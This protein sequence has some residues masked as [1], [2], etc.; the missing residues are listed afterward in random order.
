MLSEESSHSRF[1]IV[2][3][4][5][6]VR[7][8]ATCHQCESEQEYVVRSMTYLMSSSPNRESQRDR[9]PRSQAQKLSF[10]GRLWLLY[11]SNLIRC[12]WINRQRNLPN[13][14]EPWTVVRPR[15]ASN[16]LARLCSTKTTVPHLKRVP[17]G[18]RQPV[19]GLSSP[20]GAGS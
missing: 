8:T 20:Y 1:L 18:P 16:L 17:S 5:M 10:P 7:E 2:W 13:I 3:G 19:S 9:K 4:R 6:D 12:C 11:I 15:R 14:C